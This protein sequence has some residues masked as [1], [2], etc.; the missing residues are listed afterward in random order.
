[1]KSFIIAALAT[2]VAAQRPGQAPYYG[3]PGR[4][5]PPPPQQ[6]GPP[7]PAQYGYGPPQGN[8]ASYCESLNIPSNRLPGYG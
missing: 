8:I 4:G 3:P 2:L 6:Y 1:M 7:P 5:G